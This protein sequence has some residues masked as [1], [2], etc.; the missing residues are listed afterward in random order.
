MN[1]IV[2]FKDMLS[3]RIK[4]TF[5][6]MKLLYFFS[7]EKATSHWSKLTS[8]ARQLLTPPMVLAGAWFSPF[9]S[10]PN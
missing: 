5:I 9:A 7:K 1:F 8:G 10:S 6:F 4:L 2:L 3:R